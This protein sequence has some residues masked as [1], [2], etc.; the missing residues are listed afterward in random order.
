MK[1]VSWRVKDR[2]FI[3]KRTKGCEEPTNQVKGNA[4]FNNGCVIKIYKCKNKLKRKFIKMITFQR[5]AA[6]PVSERNQ[7]ATCYVG[8]LD[9]KVKESLNDNVK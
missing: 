1:R 6:G 4:G 7:D 5:M 9:E 2:I 8:G 3:T